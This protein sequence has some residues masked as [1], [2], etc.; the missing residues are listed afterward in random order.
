M[1]FQ[2]AYL[3]LEAGVPRMQGP[4]TTA[5]HE[6]C[7]EAV[8]D[9]ELFLCKFRLSVEYEVLCFP[10]LDVVFLRATRPIRH[11]DQKIATLVPH[12]VSNTQMNGA[13][14]TPIQRAV[15]LSSMPVVLRPQALR[16]LP[17]ERRQPAS[18]SKWSGSLN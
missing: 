12:V 5:A 13:R 6:L 2:S 11:A 15:I 10:L 8:E 16:A 4:T 14:K 7:A 18:Y 9:P 17:P 1:I 3:E